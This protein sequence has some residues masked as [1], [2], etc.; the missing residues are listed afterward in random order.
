MLKTKRQFT[1]VITPK[2]QVFKFGVRNPCGWQSFIPKHV[3]VTDNRDVIFIVFA[4]KILVSLPR[5][6]FPSDFCN[7][8]ALC[9][10]LLPYSCHFT[11][12]TYI[13]QVIIIFHR[14]TYDYSCLAPYGGPVEPGVALGG[15]KGSDYDQATGLAITFMVNNYHNK[16]LLEPAMEWESRL[17]TGNWTCCKEVRLKVLTAVSW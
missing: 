8:N 16:T 1:P 15:F 2:I 10:F 12:F 4:L 6:S 11:I 9:I 17:V 7:Q 3:G 5:V 13:S 14:N